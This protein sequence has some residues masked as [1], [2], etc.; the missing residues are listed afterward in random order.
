MTDALGT[1]S[2]RA[3]AAIA[4]IG[5][6]DDLQLR[7]RLRADV[8]VWTSW[9]PVARAYESFLKAPPAVLGAMGTRQL[10]VTVWYATRPEAEAG[11]LA[12]CARVA[13]VLRTLPGPPS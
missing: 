4:S 7:T 10:A 12:L 5:S 9:L 13:D 3:L 6:A 1:L 8:E 2:P 11:Q